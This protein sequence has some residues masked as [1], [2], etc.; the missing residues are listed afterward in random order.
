M[1]VKDVRLVPSQGRTCFA[2]L[3]ANHRDAAL[4]DGRRL[5]L[6]AEQ[7]AAAART[8]DNIVTRTREEV[9]DLLVE[10]VTTR[11]MMKMDQLPKPHKDA[12]KERI[13]STP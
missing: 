12:V 9:V 1:L 7:V 4:L 6:V 3:K 13:G 10:A 2:Q 11:G 8:D 5:A